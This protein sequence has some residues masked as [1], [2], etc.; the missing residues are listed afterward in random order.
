MVWFV[1]FVHLSRCVV[2]ELRISA[3]EVVF[4]GYYQCVISNDVGEDSSYVY[5]SVLP[6][7]PPT[8]RAVGTTLS[9]LATYPGES[10]YIQ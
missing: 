3:L 2:D 7:T 5:V 9:L 10:G 1:L 4:T 8:T 6:A